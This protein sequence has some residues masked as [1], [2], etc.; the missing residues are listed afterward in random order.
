MRVFNWLKAIS[1]PE[2]EIKPEITGWLKKFAKKPS[3]NKP[4]MSNMPPDKNAKVMAT[5]Q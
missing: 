2:A 5:C 1:K 3:R 4:M